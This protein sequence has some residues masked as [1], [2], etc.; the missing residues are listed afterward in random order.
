MEIETK[1]ASL[2]TFSVTIRALHVNGKQM[3]LAVFRQLPER[4][5]GKDDQPWGIVRY[6]IKDAG[7]VWL[8]Y[9]SDSRL[10]RRAIN[11]RCSKAS[12]LPLAA[13]EQEIQEE[14]EAREW[15]R[16]ISMRDIADK[17]RTVADYQARADAVPFN[18]WLNTPE[19]CRIMAER[20]R[21]DIAKEIREEQERE[22]EHAKKLAK[23]A[24]ELQS[25]LRVRRNEEN[26]AAYDQSLI[27]NLPQLFIAV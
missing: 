4:P 2:E 22:A 25:Y 6:A 23:L 20:Y 15:S 12:G 21:G 24:A 10:Y 19:E 1:T 3:T 8:V 17:E 11:T 16:K 18:E 13:C 9:S 7:D 27:D 26:R 5:E 14:H